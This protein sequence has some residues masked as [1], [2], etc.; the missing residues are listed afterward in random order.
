MWIQN[1]GISDIAHWSES[2]TSSP[3]DLRANGQSPGEGKEAA[4]AA[5]WRAED[6]A[7]ARGELLAAVHDLD[8]V[9]LWEVFCAIDGRLNDIAASDDNTSDTILLELHRQ[10]EGACT[11]AAVVPASTMEA[12]RAKASMLL[13]VLD[14]V[15]PTF[16]TRGVHERL[17]E[18]LA[19]D[20]L[21]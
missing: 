1:P 18:S 10:W 6:P 5:C 13:Q 8:L 3:H 20:V 11:R 17:A 14:V 4:S 2:V 16:A 15:A 9:S 7:A 12:Q 21:R 19:R